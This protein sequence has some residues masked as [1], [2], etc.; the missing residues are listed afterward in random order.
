M[1]SQQRRRRL[2]SPEYGRPFESTAELGEMVLGPVWLEPLLDEEQEGTDHA[3][4]APRLQRREQVALA[5]VAAL[6]HLPATQRAVLLL[7]EVLEYSAAETAA[8]LGSSVA[9]VNSALQRAQKSLRQRLPA[10][11]QAAEQLALGTEDLNRLLAAFMQAREARHVD[12]LVALLTEDVRF[13]MPP[14]PA[15]FGGR[16]FVKRFLAERVFETPWRLLPL[17]ANGQP[18]YAC[19][20]VSAGDGHFRLGGILLNL[21]GGLISGLHS[22]LDPALQRH[23]GL[24]AELSFEHDR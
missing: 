23:F 14:L 15:W 11:S 5:F 22:F 9:S 24:A 10:V 1:L 4:P 18:G 6:Q 16:H 21:R 17:R 20:M 7:R 3:D 13:T 19:Y 12:G 8:M 2:T